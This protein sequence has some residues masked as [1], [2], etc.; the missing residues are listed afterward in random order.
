[1]QH[2]VGA[3]K[4]YARHFVTQIMPA[5]RQILRGLADDAALLARHDGRP[6]PAVL[7]EMLQEV[8]DWPE[9]ILR[10]AEKRIRDYF[11]TY[12][13][14]FRKVYLANC[15][16]VH[17][18]HANDEADQPTVDVP[19]EDDVV[20]ALL[21]E[22]AAELVDSPKLVLQALSG[23]ESLR[24]LNRILDETLHTALLSMVP[25]EDMEGAEGDEAEPIVPVGAQRKAE[26]AADKEEEEEGEQ[27]EEAPEEEEEDLPVE[28]EEAAAAEEDGSIK[29]VR[30]DDW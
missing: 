29:R 3:E 19:E 24:E 27:V 21:E 17:A 1:M 7:R 20:R 23:G 30:V 16:I 6:V 2:V 25:I 18:V 10:E 28:G 9:S 5:V 14:V 11:P 8:P 15:V 12:M 13:A 4:K 22:V 26:A